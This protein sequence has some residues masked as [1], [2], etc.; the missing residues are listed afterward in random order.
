MKLTELNNKK[1]VLYIGNILILYS[2]FL[3]FGVFLVMLRFFDST[4]NASYDER[5]TIFFDK[6]FVVGG[7]FLSI[8]IIIMIILKFYRQNFIIL[9]FGIFTLLTYYLKITNLI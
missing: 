1:W 5:I 9:I 3:I 2:S 4:G 7:I 6:A 8:C